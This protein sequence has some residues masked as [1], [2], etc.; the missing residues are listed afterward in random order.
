MT[1]DKELKFALTPEALEESSRSN[2]S[3]RL[4]GRQVIF[5]A[6]E[7]MHNRQEKTVTH[8]ELINKYNDDWYI[9]NTGQSCWSDEKE[10]YQ[11]IGE[12]LNDK[13]SF[14]QIFLPINLNNFLCNVLYGYRCIKRPFDAI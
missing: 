13:H 4:P 12:F 1:S 14:R 6:M 11:E 3:S 2:E 7:I 10:L 9:Y 8:S 5:F